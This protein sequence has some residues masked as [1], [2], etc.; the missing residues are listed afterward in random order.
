MGLVPMFHGYGLLVMCMCMSFGNKV[1]VLKYFDPDLFLKSIE[2]QKVNA[3]DYLFIVI[4]LY[5]IIH[6]FL[7]RLQFYLL[8]HH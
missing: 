8:F 1:V 5:N 4:K 6:S 2:V 7:F 3:F